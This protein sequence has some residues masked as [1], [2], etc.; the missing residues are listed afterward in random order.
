MKAGKRLNQLESVETELD[1]IVL[2]Y[3][4]D[5]EPLNHSFMYSLVSHFFPVSIHYLQCI[6][7]LYHQ[8]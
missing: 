3:C 1:K 5:T 6:H 8:T 7:C 4:K 2:T